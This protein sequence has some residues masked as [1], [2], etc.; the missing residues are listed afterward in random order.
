M[1]RR[2]FSLVE[3]IIVVAILGIMAAI[4]VPQF[5]TNSTQA[6]GAVAKDSLRILRSAIEL[7]TAQHSGVPP[8]YEEDD[9]QIT[10]TNAT[11]VEQLV[12]SGKYLMKMPKNPFNDLQN[13]MIVG[14]SQTFPSSPV[15]GYGWIYQPATKT[16]KLSWPGVDSDGIAY[17]NF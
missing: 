6:K 16:I 13:I 8:G 9:P 12:S 14:N 15:D 3:L 11:F 2:G 5:Q 7:Y 1:M 4:V 10:P 17:Y